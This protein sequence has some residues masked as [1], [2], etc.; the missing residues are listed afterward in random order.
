MV[1]QPPPTCTRSPPTSQEPHPAPR[2]VES[3]QASSRVAQ[4]EAE[5]AQLEDAVARRQQIGVATGLLAQRFAQ[6]PERAWSVL[7]CL[8]QN[9]HVKVRNIAQARINAHCG[10]LSPAEVEILSAI[11]N[12]SARRRMSNRCPAGRAAPISE[13]SR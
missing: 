5:V 13:S 8:S 1:S 4:R 2:L 7:V 3:L 9:C 6:H 10:R 11:E 12:A